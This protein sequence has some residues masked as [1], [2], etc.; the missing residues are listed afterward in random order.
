MHDK[1]LGSAS[2]VICHVLEQ[3]HR[4]YMYERIEPQH[5]LLIAESAIAIDCYGSPRV[6]WS[7]G[8]RDLSI[9]EQQPLQN[10]VGAAACEKLFGS[11]WKACTDR[12]R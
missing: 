9:I 6:I 7:W 11:V 1:C 12:A 5:P 4:R 8:C 3:L 10:E 2:H